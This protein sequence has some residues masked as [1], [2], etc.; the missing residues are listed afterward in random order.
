[1][2][3]KILDTPLIIIVR[4]VCMDVDEQGEENLK[5]KINGIF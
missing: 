4:L 2:G 1:M 3:M 5:F